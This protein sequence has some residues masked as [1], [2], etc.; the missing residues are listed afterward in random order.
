[1]TAERTKP[2]FTGKSVKPP[3]KPG[4]GPGRPTAEIIALR[5]EE[6]LDKALDF[7][8]DN[9]FEAT[10]IDAICNAVGMSRRTIY[11]R[12]GDKETLF[13]AALQRVIDQWIVPVDTMRSQE[14][15]DLERTL[16]NI[17]LM[18]VANIRQPSGM[19][20]V[21]IANTEVFRRPEIAEYL[22]QRTAQ[23]TLDYLTDLFRRRLRPGDDEVPDAE[24]A[25]TAFLIL[26]VEGSIQLAV[27]G[28]M[29]D[30]DFERQIA[31]RVRLFLKG[32][33]A[34]RS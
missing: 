27:W 24:D 3:R 2:L 5:N 12:Y 8:L 30:D 28:R 7:F 9:G 22:W 32:A 21:R 19:R 14:C 29:P 23:T 13:K 10:T 26:V 20:L 16:H 18:W 4:R 1:M 34:V 15:D 6:L 25:A 17:A 31:Y 11:S 33:P